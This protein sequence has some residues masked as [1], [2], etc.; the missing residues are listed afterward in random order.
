MKKTIVKIFHFFNQFICAQ[1]L[2]VM[3]VVFIEFYYPKM[4][5]DAKIVIGGFNMLIKRDEYLNKLI[6]KNG[7]IKVITGI[8]RCGKSYLLFELLN[9]HILDISFIS[10]ILFIY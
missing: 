5:L 2:E 3:L 9:S 6:S 7:M 1:P 4:R 10:F 8:R